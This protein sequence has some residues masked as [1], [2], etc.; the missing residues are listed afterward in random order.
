MAFA[1]HRATLDAFGK[2]HLAL[3]GLYGVRLTGFLL[4]R[5]RLSAYQPIKAK[6]EAYADTLSVPKVGWGGRGGRDE[7]ACSRLCHM[8]CCP[9]VTLPPSACSSVHE[10]S[11][12]TLLPRPKIS[13]APLPL[14]RVFMW[15]G[16][17]LLYLSM[18]MPALWSARP[19]PKA[20]LGSP[21]GIVS[22]ACLAVSGA[23]LAWEA[24][25]DAVQQLYYE[26][27]GKRPCRVGPWAVDHQANYHVSRAS[28]CVR[29]GG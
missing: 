24:A 10:P 29:V 18:F 4:W 20:P 12:S 23:C 22:T 16:C 19:G 9:C 2:A 11:A 8:Q 17:S 28:A 14:Q 1:R 15:A 25:A 6:H 21:L 5:D 27:G 7:R 26:R 3:V 13:S